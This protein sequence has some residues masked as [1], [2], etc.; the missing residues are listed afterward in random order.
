MGYTDEL[1]R[2]AARPDADDLRSAIEAYYRYFKLAGK[3]EKEAFLTTHGDSVE[4]FFFTYE[5][6]DLGIALVALAA[7]MFD[8]REF[9]FLIAAGPLEDI[10]QK[11]NEEI[12][13]R[14]VIEARKNA[15]IRWMLT[16]IFLHAIS[17]D[18][19]PHIIAA[20]GTMKEEDPMPPRS[21]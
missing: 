9:M 6:P 1:T 21:R 4:L 14:V 13:E 10:L 5:D 3:E 18:A 19:R 11:P 17:D 7:S 8:D 2:A 12:I 15:R 16:G 20:I